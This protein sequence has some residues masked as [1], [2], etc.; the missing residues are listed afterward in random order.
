MPEEAEAVETY[1]EGA[2]FVEEDGGPEGDEAE[3]GGGRGEGD[4]G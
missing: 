4:D 3:E 2:S 1:E